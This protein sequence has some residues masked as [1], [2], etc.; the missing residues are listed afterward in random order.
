M[1][2]TTKNQGG[3]SSATSTTRFYWS[4]NTTLDASDQ[5]IGSRSVP[6]LAPG[7][8]ASVTTTLTVPAKAAGG[9]Y[10]VIAQADG[11]SEVPETTET[12]NTKFSAAIKVGPDLIVTAM[13]APASAA[14]GGTISVTDTTKNQGAGT[15]GASSTGFYLSANTTVG[16]GDEF[17]GS[18]SL[19]ELASNGTSTASTPLQIPADTYPAATTSLAGPIGTTTSRKRVRPTTINRVESSGLAETWSC[20]PCPSPPRAWRAVPLR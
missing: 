10:Y 18:R 7:A 17:I 11:A 15:A 3:G 13:S 9:T 4:T 8:S 2:D 5:V 1:S 16:P 12:N 20:R 19:G 14:A 6:L